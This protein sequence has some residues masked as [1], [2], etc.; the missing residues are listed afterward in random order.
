MCVRHKQ[1]RLRTVFMCDFLAIDGERYFIIVDTRTKQLRFEHVSNAEFE[2]FILAVIA[3]K[4]GESI[5]IVAPAS[6]VSA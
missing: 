4:D 6:A 2:K 1:E 5:S 3:P